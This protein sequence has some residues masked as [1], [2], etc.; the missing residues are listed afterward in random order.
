[1]AALTDEQ[2]R[3]IADRNV[4]RLMADLRIAEQE[5]ALREA[6][7]IDDEIAE[8]NFWAIHG[9]STKDYDDAFTEA[10]Q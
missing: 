8:W 4:N 10:N 2:R 1:M 6:A 5:G 7:V 3:E 9:M